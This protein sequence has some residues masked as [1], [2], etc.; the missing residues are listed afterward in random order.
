[1]FEV[2]TG[3][4]TQAVT[5]ALTIDRRGNIRLTR[6]AYKELGEPSAVQLLYDHESKTIGLRPAERGGADSYAVR[7]GSSITVSGMAFVRH[8]GIVPVDERSS[9]AYRWPAKVRDGILCVDVSEPGRPVT[10]NRA[11]RPAPRTT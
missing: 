2:F 4:N 9:S 8:Y 3:K 7:V 5:P 1:M 6:A 11:V 10:S